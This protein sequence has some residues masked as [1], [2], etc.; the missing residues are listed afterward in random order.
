MDV[1]ERAVIAGYDALLTSVGDRAAEIGSRPVV[2]HWPHVGSAYRGL[3]MFLMMAEVSHLAW[4]VLAVLGTWH[5][6]LL[7]P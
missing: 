6:R 5:L 1:D 4:F 2:T 7:A 3:V